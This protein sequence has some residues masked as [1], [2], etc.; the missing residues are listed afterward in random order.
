MGVTGA[1]LKTVDGGGFIA[2]NSYS[3]I[4]PEKFYLSQNYPNPFNPVTNLEFGVSDFGFVSL[5]VFDV[6]RKGSQNISQ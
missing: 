4:I 5:K 1:I 2:V 6:T 3:E